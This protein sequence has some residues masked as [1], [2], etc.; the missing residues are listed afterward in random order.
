MQKQK[1]LLLFGSLCTVSQKDWAAWADCVRHRWSA[2]VGSS[3]RAWQGWLCLPRRSPGLC[4]PAGAQLAAK[5]RI[6]SS[7]SA[8]THCLVLSF[9][10]GAERRVQSIVTIKPEMNYSSQNKAVLKEWKYNL[11]RLSIGIALDEID[12]E[13][14]RNCYEEC[15]VGSWPV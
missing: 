15:L 12:S 7:V 13:N 6:P 9:T 5:P 1:P 3:C 10:V 14:V 8:V 4:H 2:Y 11:Q